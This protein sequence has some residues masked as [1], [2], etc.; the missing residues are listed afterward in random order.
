MRRLRPVV[1]AVHPRACGEHALSRPSTRRLDGSSPRVRGTP[2]AIGRWRRCAA[3]HPR[4]CGERAVRSARE[5]AMPRFIPARAG[6]TSLIASDVAELR[7]FIP[8]RA[9][10]TSLR[11]HER[12][13][14]AGSSPR[15]RGTRASPDRRLHCDR[16]IPARANAAAALAP[17]WGLRHPGRAVPYR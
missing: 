14:R 1:H 9:G 7:R 6:N 12:R 11:S 16:F 4:A 17:G 10:N 5:P 3:V 15:V 8:A 13:A 2:R